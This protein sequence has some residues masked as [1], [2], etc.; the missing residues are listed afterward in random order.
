MWKDHIC[1]Y[2]LEHQRTTVSFY[3]MTDIELLKWGKQNELDTHVVLT[4]NT[5]CKERW[6]RK[7]QSSYR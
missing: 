2:I 4:L 5:A 6:Q 3:D 1:R 7:I